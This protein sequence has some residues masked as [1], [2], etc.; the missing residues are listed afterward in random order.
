[1][2]NCSQKE[3]ASVTFF[4]KIYLVSHVNSSLLLKTNGS[5]PFWQLKALFTTINQ[6]N[7]AFIFAVINNKT[8]KVVLLKV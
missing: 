2:Q 5:G 1:M 8:E 3:V 7:Y 4:L 6:A